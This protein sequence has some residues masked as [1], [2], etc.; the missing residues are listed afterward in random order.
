MCLRNRGHTPLGQ[1]LNPSRFI[2]T[3]VHTITHKSRSSRSNIVGASGCSLGSGTVREVTGTMSSGNA[4]FALCGALTSP[5][6]TS[7]ARESSLDLI[8]T[9]SWHL[10]LYLQHRPIASQQAAHWLFSPPIAWN[11]PV[12]TSEGI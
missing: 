7:L 6:A 8:A 11:I 5:S 12:N 4:T 9:V 1:S 10:E 3:Y 2:D